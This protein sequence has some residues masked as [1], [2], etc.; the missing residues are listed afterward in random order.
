MKP[1][2]FTADAYTRDASFYA[3]MKS[4]ETFETAIDPSTLLILSTESELFQYLNEPQ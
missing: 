3:F 4:M 1:H 2:A